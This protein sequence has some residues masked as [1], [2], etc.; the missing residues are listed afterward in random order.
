MR[1]RAYNRIFHL[2]RQSTFYRVLVVYTTG[3][4]LIFI[5][6]TFF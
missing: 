4:V 5:K 6:I 1:D 3:G 2:A